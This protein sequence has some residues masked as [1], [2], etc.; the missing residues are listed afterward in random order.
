MQ[1]HQFMTERR[2]QI[3]DACS[4]ELNQAKGEP[5][6]AEYV[7]PFFDETL[8]AMRRDAGVR[9]SESPLP[10][11]SDTAARFGADRQRAGLPVTDVPLLFK[12]IS[13]ALGKVGQQYDLTI[14]AEEYKRLNLCLDAGLATSVENFWRNDRNRESRMITERFGF[15]A[16]EL[17]NALGNANL[18][19]KLLRTGSVGVNGRTAGVLARNLVKMEALVAQVLSSVQLEAGVAPELAATRVATVLR[20]LEAA[21]IPDRDITVQ[22]SLDEQVFISADEQLLTSAISNLLHNAI[23][24]SPPGSTVRLGVHSSEG[25]AVIEVEDQCGGLKEDAEEVF[26]P[27]VKQHQGNQNGT[28]LGLTIAKRAVEAMRGQLRVADRPGHG[29]SFS[30]SFPLLQR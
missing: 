12:A 7:E 14:S 3:L 22:L 6:L 11:A 9:E 24:F 28:G 23:K 1:L 13:Q 8:R 19:F 2:D 26:R 29:C 4:V 30:A 15:I 25:S 20:N 27:F 18:A 21:A 17:R 10:G 16:H 5:L